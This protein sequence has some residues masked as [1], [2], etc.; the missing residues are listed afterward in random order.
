[1]L[2]TGVP[3]IRVGNLS[4][5][6]RWY[7]S[8]LNLPEHQYCEDGDLLFAWSATFGAFIWRG[9][10]AIFHYHI[11]KVEPFENLD[12]EFAY[13]LLQHITDS[14]KAASHGLAM[15]HMTKHSMEQWH[16]NLPPK[17]EQKRIAAILRERLN[18]IQRAREA[19]KE[20]LNAICTLPSA[21]L[22]HVFSSSEAGTWQRKKLGEISRLTSGGTPSRNNPDF[23]KGEISWVKTLDLNCSHIKNTEEQISEAA[24][25]EIRGEIL[26]I[27]TV[28][29]AM[30]GGA[31][32]IGK[33]GILDIPATTNQAICSI[34][35]NESEFIPEF[36]NFWLIHIRAEW[37]KFSGGNRKDPNINKEIVNQMYC[38][39]PSLDRQKQLS[40]KLQAQMRAVEIIRKQI[41]EQL[42][43]VEAY[44][45]KL[46]K[47]AFNGQL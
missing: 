32:T 3:I 13:H 5:N 31:G 42:E 43:A 46:L 33:S 35:P 14:V 36:L 34:L 16:V 39:L 1:M 7:Y 8:N 40:K 18:A 28:M 2:D 10:R 25:K 19:A 22:R 30:Y 45:P 37:M 6:T 9:P 4:G 23:F 38:P 47:C 26:P 17:A 12:K 21:Y 15:L 29:V 20:Q 27:G 11:W 44:Y 24:F 41:E